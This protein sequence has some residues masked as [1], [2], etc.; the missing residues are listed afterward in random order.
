MSDGIGE[1][2]TF[3][4]IA[5]ITRIRAMGCTQKQVAELTGLC[6]PRISNLMKGRLERFTC[7]AIIELLYRLGAEVSMKVNDKSP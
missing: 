3:L 4:A 2:K 5:A 7:D 1:C 6:Q